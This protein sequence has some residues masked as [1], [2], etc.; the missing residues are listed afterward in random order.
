MQGATPAPSLVPWRM[1]PRPGSPRRSRCSRQ[2][3]A[4]PTLANGRSGIRTRAPPRPPCSCGPWPMSSA[5][6][7]PV[8]QVEAGAR[9]SGPVLVGR[10]GAPGVGVGRALIV[11]PPGGPGSPQVSAELGTTA[12]PAA[13]AVRLRAALETAANDL[14]ELA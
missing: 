8:A 9:P 5:A 12:D 10:V 11:E 14:T 13:E 4:P 6:T 7:A 2:K 3:A 1:P